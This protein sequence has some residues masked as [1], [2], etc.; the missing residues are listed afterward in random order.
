MAF[1]ASASAAAL[2]SSFC[3]ISSAAVALRSFQ[4]LGQKVRRNSAPSL[5]IGGA[6]RLLHPRRTLGLLHGRIEQADKQR[7]YEHTA[8]QPKDKAQRAAIGD[9]A[10]D[11]T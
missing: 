10:L 2:G 5:Q 4:L 7:Q 1:F 8:C 6:F 3:I 9:N 11:R